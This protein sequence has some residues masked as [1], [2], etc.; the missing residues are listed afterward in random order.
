MHVYIHLK[1]HMHAP[2]GTY[3]I[4]LK[5]KTYRFGISFK[6]NGIDF[7]LYTFVCR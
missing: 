1:V 3:G 5:Y 2:S 6:M 7:L 4:L